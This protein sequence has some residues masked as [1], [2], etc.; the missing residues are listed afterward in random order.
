MSDFNCSLLVSSCDKYNDLWD[1][2]FMC[3]TKFWPQI[4]M[5]I[6]LNTESLTY[7]PT[8]EIPFNICTLK[9][10]Q[11]VKNTSWSQRFIDALNRIESEYI[12]LMLDDYFICNEVSEND[13]NEL[14]VFMENNPDV[15]S[16]QLNWSLNKEKTSEQAKELKPKMISEDGWKAFFTPTIWRKSILLKWLRPWENVWAF[17]DCGSK[18]ANRWYKKDKV[19]IVDDYPIIDYLWVHDCSAVVN[20]KWIK[21][22]PVFDF[23]NSTGIDIDYSN[24]GFITYDEYHAITMAD[25]IKKYS[26]WE[27]VKKT[28]NRFRSI[29]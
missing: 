27:V 3:L 7:E 26:F 12:I 5:P 24:R 15:A 4:K 19:Y 22:Q 14:L 6:Y 16:V 9:Q 17:E 23:F 11:G 28:V 8:E 21:E 13:I 2:F 25:I 29:F 10:K 20:G 18:R 1:P